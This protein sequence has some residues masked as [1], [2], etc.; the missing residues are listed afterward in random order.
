MRYLLFLGIFT[1]QVLILTGHPGWGLVTTS[2]GDIYFTD[3]LNGYGNVWKIGKEGNAKIALSNLHSHDLF[4]EDREVLWGCD[5]RYLNKTDEWESRVWFHS[6]STGFREYIPWEKGKEQFSGTNFII[7]PDGSVI[8][9]YENQLFLR[10]GKEIKLASSFTW[11]R[12]CTLH[13]TKDGPILI[14]DSH[15]R[16]TLYQMDSEGVV[17]TLATDLKMVNPPN[18][19]YPEPRFDLFF[20]MSQKDDKVYICNSGSRRILE[21]SPEGKVNTFYESQAPWFPVGIT[22]HLEKAIVKEVGFQAGEGH[23]GPRIL[24]FTDPNRPELLFTTEDSGD[25]SPIAKPKKGSMEKIPWQWGIGAFLIAC[26]FL[27]I[28]RIFR[29]LRGEQNELI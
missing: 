8:F 11:D 13:P 21:I 18:P 20:G 23:M 16:G 25:S 19:P 10:K 3:I 5:H 27:I 17:T 6:D 29:I 15:E 14:S 4:L 24:R 12:I 7:R 2:S 26:L 28:L 22:F 9:D 1:C